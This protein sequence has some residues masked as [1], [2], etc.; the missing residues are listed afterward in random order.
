MISNVELETVRARFWY[1]RRGSRSQQEAGS[2]QSIWITRAS[3]YIYGIN[4]KLIK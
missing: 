1:A 2:F 4:W 3:E